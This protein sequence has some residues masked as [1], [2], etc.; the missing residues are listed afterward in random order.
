MVAERNPQSIYFLSGSDSSFHMYQTFLNP[1][2]GIP[3]KLWTKKRFCPLKISAIV[4]I[5]H[6]P[7]WS[8]Y[9]N[10]FLAV[11]GPQGDVLSRFKKVFQVSAKSFVQKTALKTFFLSF[12]GALKMMSRT[13]TFAKS[14]L[15]C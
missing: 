5:P 3:A 15:I 2:F 1:Q 12:L 10:N 4:H 14:L 9:P 13:S 8:I 11:S 6:Y 7:R